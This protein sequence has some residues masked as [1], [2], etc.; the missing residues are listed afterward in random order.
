MAFPKKHLSAGEYVVDHMHTHPKVLGWRILGTVLLITVA[1]IASVIA[2]QSWQPWGLYA[3]WIL[4]L[5][6]A[7]PLMIIPWLEWLNKTFT[8]TNRRIITRKGIFNKD[9]H[10]I[11]LSRISDIRYERG[12]TDRIFGCGTLILETS[13]EKPV[14]LEDIPKIETVHVRLA[15]ML[16]ETDADADDRA[17]GGYDRPADPQAPAGPGARVEGWLHSSRLDTVGSWRGVDRAGQAPQSDSQT[18]LTS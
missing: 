5:I 10:D 14:R 8:I 13:A 15:N 17:A 18:R 3:I 11:P 2:P 4:A 6:V 16:F 12:W 9:G 1:I 7:F